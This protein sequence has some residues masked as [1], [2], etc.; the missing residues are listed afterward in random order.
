[1][2]RSDYTETPQIDC[3][4]NLS[5]I[6]PE[7]YDFNIPFDG[8][9]Y[10]LICKSPDDCDGICPLG[11]DEELLLNEYVEVYRQKYNRD[12][13]G[14][15][16]FKAF[17]VYDGDIISGVKREFLLIKNLDREVS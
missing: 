6:K 17:P 8:L 3:W 16:P 12:I 2:I 1:M 10:A 11:S 13:M 4:M 7:C 5:G 14:K 15:R 9:R